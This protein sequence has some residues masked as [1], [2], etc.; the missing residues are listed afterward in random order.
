MVPSLSS[1]LAESFYC[2]FVFPQILQWRD[3]TYTYIHPLP[4]NQSLKMVFRRSL[5]M[6]IVISESNLEEA[7][8]VIQTAPLTKNNSI[9]STASV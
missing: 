4:L 1:R 7:L 5:P 2:P 8:D 9:A 3:S 6:I